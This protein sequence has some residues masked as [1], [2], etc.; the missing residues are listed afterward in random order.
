M[1]STPISTSPL[2][3][4]R[5]PSLRTMQQFFA[6]F[7]IALVISLPFYAADVFADGAIGS[8]AA[9]G[10]DNV[11]GVMRATDGLVIEAAITGL[12][13]TALPSQ[14]RLGT[15]Q[16]FDT[17]SRG[18][19][20]SLCRIRFP[21]SG[22]QTFDAKEMPFTVTLFD[23]SNA[24][25]DSK[26]GSVLVDGAKPTFAFTSISSQ[27]AGNEDITFSYTAKDT[28]CQ[29]SS[30][31]GKCS[32]IRKVEFFTLDNA[33][34]DMVDVNT[35]S[36][37][38]SST[39]VKP[40]SSF[41]T[42][43]AALFARV[44]DMVGQASNPLSITFA[45]DAT[46]PLFLP[47]SMKI[48]YRG[49]DLSYFVPG[50]SFPAIV[51]VNITD[52]A[53]NAN[54]VV[55][56]F[57]DLNPADASV[58]NARGRCASTGP[59]VSTCTWNINLRIS[60][61]GLKQLIFNAS[62]SKG[63]YEAATFVRTFTADTTGP[64][65]LSIAGA[66]SAGDTL[67]ARPMGSLQ[68]AITE[69]G[70]GMLPGEMLLSV[71][72]QQVAATNC[73]ATSCTWDNVPLTEGAE[74]VSISSSSADILGNKALSFSQAI[75]VD[76]RAPEIRKVI[77]QGIGGLTG[78]PS[79]FAAVG[80]RIGILVN[81]SEET[82]M[83][84][85]TADLSD[86][87]PNAAAAQG[88]CENA[89][90]NMFLCTIVSDPVEMAATGTVVITASD[91]AGNS[92]TFQKPMQTYGVDTSTA[93]N[94]WSS[95]VS[96]SPQ[97]L[98]R[99]LGPL[100][101]QRV[102]C[103]VMLYRRSG[104]TTPKTI[105]ISFAGCTGDGAGSNGN[106]IQSAE[107]F[108]AKPGSTTPLIKLVFG[109]DSLKINEV[110]TSCKLNILSIANGMVTQTP[111]TEIVHATTQ[112]YNNPLGTV[113]ESVQAKIDEA[114]EKT[115]GVWKLIGILSKISKIAQQVCSI[116]KSLK[117]LDGY[118]STGVFAAEKGA[119]ALCNPLSSITTLGT[120]CTSAEAARKALCNAQQ[121]KSTNTDKGIQNYANKFCNWVNCE[122]NPGILG[123][124]QKG[125]TGMVNSLPGSQ[126]LGGGGYASAL[127]P[128]KS[129]VYAILTGCI[130]GIIE[131]LDRYRQ[132][133]C[134]YAD[135]LKTAVQQDNLP[136]E[137]CETLKDQATCKYVMGE[138]FALIPFVALFDKY[139]GMLKDALSDPFSA[140]GL[141]VGALCQATCSMPTFGTSLPYTICQ[142]FKVLSKIG[143]MVKKVQG[144]IQAVQGKG[145]Y[146]SKLEESE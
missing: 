59:N 94:Y 65:V 4:V 137:V 33:F 129:I 118:L 84:G 91:A 122:Q 66:G 20:G 119:A 63:N 128:H 34:N 146:C 133:D 96:C 58:R 143:E 49:K 110:S 79:D 144:I 132:I 10:K 78:V 88:T 90:T 56:S 103:T 22:E 41:A 64:Q 52:S 32:G 9:K 19:N 37:T 43:Q 139:A 145:D 67:F 135:C 48:L 134:L 17:C 74:E 125:I 8:V 71:Q 109:R 102:Y 113:D 29:D 23:E 92:A 141:G 12:A 47:D 15:S 114:M 115:R 53:L 130:P 120:A 124:M 36:C 50:K 21:P 98:D 89:G 45:V 51:Q 83:G 27:N 42:G 104:Q 40:A 5:A 111:E 82:Q 35:R 61:A 97:A 24:T 108:N 2:P 80:D 126:L 112:F 87:I 81:V 26:P 1:S 44:T 60:T 107:L 105:D 101:E 127:N 16:N 13:G 57:Q 62:D 77:I 11:N 106:L 18:M 70:A 3:R 55:G 31:S 6:A 136:I 14:V 25:L 131:G 28:A 100:I 46:G 99:E 117:D 68:A 142:T 38:Y 39:Y 69:N 86:F 72:G 140:V 138:I 54:A 73:T 116:F 93:P 75:T 123:D 85:I 7:I 95:S 121:T 76:S 30:C